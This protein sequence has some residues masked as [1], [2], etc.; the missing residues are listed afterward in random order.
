MLKNS[1]P[2]LIIKK[3]QSSSSH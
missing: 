2:I 3:I 1:S